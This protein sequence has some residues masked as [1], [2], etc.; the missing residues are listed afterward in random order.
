[1]KM[2]TVAALAALALTL[3]A[4]G[5]A[6]GTAQ[7]DAPAP[8]AQESM[9]A[10]GPAVEETE[11]EEEG[12]SREAEALIGEWISSGDTEDVLILN[13]DGSC[14]A[15]EEPFVWTVDT[16]DRGFFR[17]E[18]QE[19]QF[20]FYFQVIKDEAGNEALHLAGLI[21][22]EEGLYFSR[23]STGKN[24]YRR[25]VIEEM[26]VGNSLEELTAVLEGTWLLASDSA[27]TASWPR[28][29][30]IE[31]DTVTIGDESFSYEFD[32]Y[33][34]QQY[35]GG[36]PDYVN[37]RFFEEDGTEKG[38][39]NFGK[40][41]FA[42]NTIPTLGIDVRFDDGTGYY[43][44]CKCE[45]IELTVDNWQD[46]LEFR[47][48]IRE[49][50]NAFNEIESLSWQK[51][52]TVKDE[53]R[54]RLIRGNAAVEFT[55]GNYVAKRVTYHPSDG[56]FT[57]EDTDENPDNILWGSADESWTEMTTFNDLSS[58]SRLVGNPV[59]EDDT[60]TPET[61]SGYVAGPSLLTIDR[62]SG[63]LYLGEPLS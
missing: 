20:G 15:G 60:S 2:K 49:N 34:L 39:L 47:D 21:P 41:Q 22:A 11:S 17:V 30:V 51:V 24:F 13:E 35:E 19:G 59:H 23:R 14:T 55:R 56:S 61:M 33:F 48:D 25:E 53:Y 5:G 6:A 7:T 10:E 8:A 37:V 26:N 9:A 18:R 16:A 57:V 12:L 32:D 46:Y 50:R 1:M 29:L 42:Q 52:L 45:R 62:L 63:A 4:C 3:S 27:D 44:Y 58:N 36:L 43:S 40:V 31:G 28:E 38:V 54:D